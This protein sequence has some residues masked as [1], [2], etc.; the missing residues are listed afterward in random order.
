MSSM[1]ITFDGTLEFGQFLGDTLCSIRAAQLFIEH[2]PCDKYYLTLNAAGQL[3]F[4]W[5]KLIDTYHVEVIETNF[6]PG[7]ADERFAAWNQWR[8]KREVNGKPFDKYRECY[9]RIDGANRQG[10]LCGGEKGL[11][12]KNIFE[13]FVY[14]QEE[15]PDVVRG[16]TDFRP[17]L[18]YH[19]PSPPRW[20]VWCSPAAKC[21]GNGVFTFQFWDAV[22]RKLVAQG[23]RVTVG[24]NGEFCEDLSGA[25]YRRVFP[26][27]RELP[28][29][30]AS[31]RL[32]TCGNTGT[33]WVAACVGTPLLSMQPPDS[34]MAD[35][36]YEWCG[37][38]SLVEYVE[39]PDVEYVVKR[40]V[41]EL[42]KKTVLTFGDYESLTAADVRH[43]EEARSLGTRLVV[44]VKDAG[45]AGTLLKGLRCVDAVKVV[46]GTVA[47]MVEE[48]RPAVVA[49]A[50]G[51][52]SLGCHAVEAFGGRVAITTG[53]P[54]VIPEPRREIKAQDV[55]KLVR[56]A[57]HLSV[58]PQAKLKLLAD[59]F[60]SVS[61]LPGDVADLGAYRGAC[62]YLLRRLAPDKELH[63]FDNWGV[64]NPHFDP[65]CHHGPGE[66]AFPLE[67]CRRN[68]G[69]DPKTHFHKGVFPGSA[70]GLEGRRFCFVFVDMD[71][72][73]STKA[74]VE[75][76]WPRLV[77]GGKMLVDDWSW[78]PCAGTEK[79]V[80]EL[81]EESQLRI[82]PEEHACLLTK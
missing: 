51:G 52:D 69:A 57:E 46:D 64:G 28:D 71:T 74:A 58:N 12:R 19:K 59:Q 24:H 82:Y 43:L 39:A 68:V 38:R 62:A 17:G 6:H 53:K 56:E 80:R 67:E 78:E 54:V 60:L 16:T 63:V 41:E 55:L 11:G 18:I 14:G 4:L 40:A 34:N 26:P 21:Q 49:V 33:G 76:F 8:E 75:F 48:L 77:A 15:V 3:N 29:E 25:Y 61:S 5:R 2:H 65:D 1:L 73:Q 23:V 70:A 9:R 81:F 30:I 35:Y 42:E 20:D 47:Q 31:H 50:E 45:D 66:W 27:F 79:A 13:Y 72:Y 32:L 10:V 7:N 36:R 22:V 37:V 44:G